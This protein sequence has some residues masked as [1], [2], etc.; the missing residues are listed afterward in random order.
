VNALNG[1]DL[2]GNYSF[3]LPAFSQIV[4]ESWIEMTLPA[5]T[6]G[7]WRKHPMLNV[8]DRITYRAGQK[9]FEFVPRKDMPLLLTRC[10][11]KAMKDQ[12]M[13]IFK[14]HSGA[15]SA[16]QA[17]T[18]CL[19]CS[20]FQSGTPTVS[21]NPSNMGTGPGGSGTLADWRITS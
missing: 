2:N 3:I 12:L 21:R 13:A 14:D 11:D 4:G 17:P 20:L 10:K 7:T 18:Y 9:F 16:T 19:L 1:V 5:L 8:V 6:D 15:A